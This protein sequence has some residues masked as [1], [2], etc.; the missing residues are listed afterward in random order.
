MKNIILIICCLLLSLSIKACGDSLQTKQINPEE[1][2][3]NI[4]LE[5][6]VNYVPINIKKDITF[7]INI[8]TLEKENQ[9]CDFSI[10]CIVNL[11]EIY[12]VR[13]I[14]YLE[15]HNQ[16]VLVRSELSI[17]KIKEVLPVEDITPDAAIRIKNQLCDDTPRFS[18]YTYHPSITIFNYNKGELIINKTANEFTVDKKYWIKDFDESFWDVKII[19]IEPDSFKKYF[20]Y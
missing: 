16:F 10:R 12:D 18:C 7:V 5:Q 9:I 14:G 6:L 11:S 15:I 17:E 19:K 4:I 20:P 2:L 1:N 13:P 3:S 8:V